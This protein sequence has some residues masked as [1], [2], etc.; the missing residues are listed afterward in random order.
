M[1]DWIRTHPD[2]G[3][4]EVC[5]NNAGITDLIHFLFCTQRLLIYATK[6]IWVGEHLIEGQ[7]DMWRRMWNLNVVASSVC[8]QHAFNLM[9]EKGS[10]KK[11]FLS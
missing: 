11:L 8:T 4:L 7:P 2:L 5:I 9:I 1:F 6:G 3:Q 10:F